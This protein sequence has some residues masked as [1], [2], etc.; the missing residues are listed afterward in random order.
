M[1]NFAKRKCKIFHSEPMQNVAMGIDYTKNFRRNL[2][3]LLKSSGYNAQTLKAVHLDGRKKGDYVASRTIAYYVS[4]SE[5]MR[6]PSPSLDILAAIAARFNLLPYHLLL[7]DLDPQVL[8]VQGTERWIEDEALRRAKTIA[9]GMV[10]IDK[11]RLHATEEHSRRNT[12]IA[13]PDSQ[14]SVLGK[15]SGAGTKQASKKA[16]GKARSPV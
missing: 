3:S 9:R 14:A 1:Q 2:Q 12:R 4:D 11:E 16:K 7:P 13:S 15:K 8:P 5:S 6:A 10:H